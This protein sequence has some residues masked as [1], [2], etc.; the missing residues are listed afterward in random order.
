MRPGEPK[1][2]IAYQRGVTAAGPV[3][4][5]C[6]NGVYRL[7]ENKDLVIGAV[8]T[9]H[10]KR[11][12]LHF[13]L[14]QSD[15]EK[16]G[17]GAAYL[18]SAEESE[19]LFLGGHWTRLGIGT[20]GAF[21]LELDDTH[22]VAKSLWCTDGKDKVQERTFTKDC[23]LQLAY[24]RDFGSF[25]REGRLECSNLCT[26]NSVS[27]ILA[28][29]G[30]EVLG[31]ANAVEQDDGSKKDMLRRTVV[32]EA[33]RHLV[34]TIHRTVYDPLQQKIVKEMR[35]VSFDPVLR[36]PEVPDAVMRAY[37]D[38]RE[39][40]L[41]SCSVGRDSRAYGLYGVVVHQGSSPGSGH[42]YSYARHSDTPDLFRPDSAN[43]PW[44]LFNDESISL[45]SWDEMT[46]AIKKKKIAYCVPAFL[47]PVKCGYRRSIS[48]E[49]WQDK[50]L[51]PAC[52]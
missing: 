21:T 34:V 39:G 15:T 4:D 12:S 22:N 3:I 32:L 24:K 27:E 48:G 9:G 52:K 37:S 41:K 45:S 2:F 25:W 43:S 5:H 1:Y 11:L 42:Y 49:L 35:D 19:S 26:G 46:T 29:T 14:W 16:E 30:A 20:S 18:F 51:G 50:R 17:T 23:Y 47:P 28:A 13:D 40:E 8:A 44:M 33:P 7:G 10:S 38:Q 36:L 6:C 31:G